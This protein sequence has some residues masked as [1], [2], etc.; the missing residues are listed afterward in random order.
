MR[1]KRNITVDGDVLGIVCPVYYGTSAYLM[2]E[3]LRNLS[4]KSN[5][6]IFLLTTCKGHTGI[7]AN[8]IDLILNKR[9][10]NA[11]RKWETSDNVIGIYTAIAHNKKVI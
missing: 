6:Y 7:V 2:M 4:F 9:Q 1:E 5:P 10:I 3:A 8:R 11:L